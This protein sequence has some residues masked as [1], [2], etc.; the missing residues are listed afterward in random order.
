MS[1]PRSIVCLTEESVE[2]LFLL[3]KE[4]LIKG[5]SIFVRRPLEATKLPKVSQFT[6]TNTDKIKTIKPDLIIGFSDIQKDTARELIAEGFNVLITNQRSINE[7]IDQIL[8]LGNIVDAKEEAQKLI[9]TIYHK[10]E[11]VKNQTREW[12]HR[13]KVYFE[14][15]DE[16]RISGIRWVSELI[17]ICG[18]DDIFHQKS[19]QSNL[20]S[21]RFVDDEHIIKE[22]PDI[23]IG[24]WCGKKV[25][26]ESIKK[27]KGME[28]VS[29]VIN[30]HVYEVPPEIFLQPGPAVL[31]DGI[32]M[33]HTLFKG[34]I[35]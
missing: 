30:N 32:D 31:T 8:F 3:Q 7:I 11:M 10:I 15:W 17:A 33:M 35:K 20:A 18:G 13:P 23:I 34:L 14:E 24:C 9:R 19:L 4:H 6:N 12:E 25:N 22:N 27:R 21:E 29:A 28:Q 26:L 16:P 2:T 5:V 1:Y